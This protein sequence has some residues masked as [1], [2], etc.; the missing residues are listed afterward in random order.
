MGNLRCSV[1]D[2]SRVSVEGLQSTCET[3]AGSCNPE[4]TSCPDTFSL[5]PINVD[6][7]SLENRFHLLAQLRDKINEEHNEIETLSNQLNEVRLSYAMINSDVETLVQKE[8]LDQVDELSDKI[9]ILGK[10]CLAMEHDRETGGHLLARS[11]IEIE[12]AKNPEDMAMVLGKAAAAVDVLGLEE[13][14]HDY[15]Q[16]AL[17]ISVAKNDAFAVPFYRL[18][19]IRTMP[20][21]DKKSQRYKLIELEKFYGE[22]LSRL[23]QIEKASVRAEIGGCMPNIDSGCSPREEALTRA[24]LADTLV[25]EVCVMIKRGMEYDDAEYNKILE[26]VLERTKVATEKPLTTREASSLTRA[27]AGLFDLN[28][29]KTS[30]D[31]LSG[32]LGSTRGLAAKMQTEAALAEKMCKAHKLKDDALV[33]LLDRAYF[34]V[35]QQ[36]GLPIDAIYTWWENVAKKYRGLESVD[37]QI[38]VIRE[39]AGHLFENGELKPRA[40]IIPPP[41]GADAQDIENKIHLSDGTF[42]EKLALVGGGSIAGTA[43]GAKLFAGAGVLCGPFAEVCVPAGGAIGGVAG[44]FAG[45][46]LLKWFHKDD[47]DEIL[48]QARLAGT[49]FLRV[50]REEANRAELN[51]YLYYYGIGVLAAAVGGGATANATKWSIAQTASAAMTREGWRAAYSLTGQRLLYSWKEAG[52]EWGHTVNFFK[53][54]YHWGKGLAGSSPKPSPFVPPNL[55]EVFELIYARLNP[56]Q[57]AAR[58]KEEWRT[59]FDDLVARGDTSLFRAPKAGGG[60]TSLP[61]GALDGVWGRTNYF[62][63]K[64]LRLDQL[65][66]WTAGHFRSAKEA[67][68]RKVPKLVESRLA[69]MG[70]KELLRH[71]FRLGEGWSPPVPAAVD[72]EASRGVVWRLWNQHLWSD[73][74]AKAY[75][76]GMIPALADYAFVKNTPDGYELALWDGQIDTA[77][78]FAGYVAGTAYYS[79]RN[80]FGVEFNSFNGGILGGGMKALTFVGFLN[81]AG[82]AV[83]D[84]D[85][86]TL[87]GAQDEYLL[88]LQETML[89]YCGMHAKGGDLVKA[90]SQIPFARRLIPSQSSF[91]SMYAVNSTLNAPNFFNAAKGARISVNLPGLLGISLP[92]NIV[93]IMGVRTVTG[94]TLLGSDPYFIGQSGWKFFFVG[95]ILN[96][97][98]MAMGGNTAAAQ[99]GT[100]L[101]GILFDIIPAISMSPYYNSRK[102]LSATLSRMAKE[103]GPDDKDEEMKL[104]FSEPDNWLSS[105]GLSDIG[106]INRTFDV[107]GGF[108]RDA[109]KLTSPATWHFGWRWEPDGVDAFLDVLEGYKD[110]KTKKHTKGVGES[111]PEIYAGMANALLNF[112][113]EPQ[114]WLNDEH[115]LRGM[116]ITSIMAK[117]L[118]LRA[119]NGEKQFQPYAELIRQS[120]PE[121]R[122]RFWDNLPAVSSR[123]EFLEKVAVVQEMSVEDVFKA[124]FKTSYEFEGGESLVH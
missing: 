13:M 52:Y 6:V 49:K 77:L 123:K 111:H 81:L 83:G 3:P 27:L 119:K 34:S 121:W 108:K 112:F 25:V 24:L 40:M 47:L 114:W 79:S 75:R 89:I 61:P 63:D 60:A 69:L 98:Q 35:Y 107:V 105:V 7:S 39:N 62:L 110:E 70:R 23:R 11:I 15:F 71:D 76:L 32:H 38:K 115:K 48:S 9:K 101:L 56:T 80:P 51:S 88:V 113:N 43:A 67:V 36:S 53:G 92:Y 42:L 104:F 100:R 17:K 8:L 26:T 54:A 90:V 64:Q 57:L 33:A 116:L 94:K 122:R 16:E 55:D 82:M 74:F 20:D 59:V 12:T 86:P 124:V 44:F 87:K 102:M 120:S 31:S 85:I 19:S 99:G 66:E 103:N 95:T 84:T 1:E 21:G 96:P 106:T 28:I 118:A 10:R 65:S 30:A 73:E 78:G 91:V 5:M 14:A 18:Q 68:A 41:D 93:N 46:K 50:G 45:D 117:W 58:T 97:T 4:I 72:A 2:F 109:F 22:T 29:K 37:A